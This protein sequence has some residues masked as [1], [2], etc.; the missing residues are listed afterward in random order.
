[1]TI[2]H[3]P[4][5][6]GYHVRAERSDLRQA[7]T[8]RVSRLP[9]VDELPAGTPKAVIDALAHWYDLRSE[10]AELRTKQRDASRAATQATTD[11]RALVRTALAEGKNA[12]EIKINA[13][14]HRTQAEALGQLAALAESALEDHG[15]TLGSIM[16]EHAADIAGLVDVE[17]DNIAEVVRETLSELEG[18]WGQWAALFGL[19]EWLSSI[20]LGTTVSPAYHGGDRHA[21]AT[22]EA[23]AP[24]LKVL[25]EP[26]RLREDER[27]VL[28]WRQLQDEA[29]AANAAMYGETA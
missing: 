20:A 11:Y 29:N 26:E 25:G 21:Q 27:A 24:I 4:P 12:A 19:R 14:A 7:F 23:S 17:L 28:S 5:M 16:E 10:A 9:L 1:M 2:K 13:D 22:S 8:P 18:N 6:N 3:I 15:F